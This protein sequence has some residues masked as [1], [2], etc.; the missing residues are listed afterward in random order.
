MKSLHRGKAIEAYKGA[1]VMEEMGLTEKLLV[2]VDVACSSLHIDS[3]RFDSI[4]AAHGRPI[5]TGRKYD[6]G[7][8]GRKDWQSSCGCKG[9]R[10]DTVWRVSR[11]MPRDS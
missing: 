7:Q 5:A 11:D 10:R 6:N 2:V 1:R 8:V 9:I 3:W 4:I